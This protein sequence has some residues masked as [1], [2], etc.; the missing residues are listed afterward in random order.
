MTIPG[1]SFEDGLLRA[2]RRQRDERGWW[3]LE[4]PIGYPK[5]LAGSRGN[6]RVDAVVLPTHPARVS[7]QLQDLAAFESNVGGC[8]V[9]LIEAKRT[10]NVDVIGQLLCGASMFTAKYPEHGPLRLTALVA[11]AGD[12]ALRWYCHTERIE[13]IKVDPQLNDPRQPS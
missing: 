12:A 10:L 2:L 1:S 11:D 4:L 6:R 5:A 7:P 9:E 8:E 3:L 13:V